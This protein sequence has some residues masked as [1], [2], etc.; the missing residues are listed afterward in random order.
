MMRKPDYV[1]RIQLW[2]ATEHFRGLLDVAVLFWRA[3]FIKYCAN[4]KNIYIMEKK[5]KTFTNSKAVVF[6]LQCYF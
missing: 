3:A 4:K 6:H 2:N 1:F 5:K